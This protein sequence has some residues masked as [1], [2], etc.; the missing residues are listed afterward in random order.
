MN[1]KQK[2]LARKLGA[3]SLAAGAAAFGASA[4][5][6]DAVVVGYRGPADPPAGMADWGL[7]FDYAWYANSVHLPPDPI[8]TKWPMI[9]F[10]LDGTVMA[11]EDL[12][13]PPDP[14]PDWW[15]E[16]A[17]GSVYFT[18]EIVEHAGKASDSFYGN[19][20]PDAG[21][22]AQKLGAGATIDGAQTYVNRDEMYFYD[23]WFYIGGTWGWGGRGYL[24]FYIDDVDG[25]HYG[26]ADICVG[27]GRNEMW[28]G[29]FAYETEPGVGIEAGQGITGD[30]DGDFDVD[31]DDIDLFCANKTGPGV[32]PADPMY[33][34][35]GDGDADDDD[36]DMLIHSFVQTDPAGDAPGTEYGDFDL[37]G[38]VDTTD[39]TILATNFNADPAG[40]AMGNANCDS[41]ID[42]TDLTILATNFGFDKFGGGV[43]EPATLSIL[44][45]GAAGLLKVRRRN[46]A[47]IK[48]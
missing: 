41:I 27:T 22:M 20:S 33:D 28:L 4:V 19:A 5:V 24:G 2:S 31:A 35:D 23:E 9:L 14:H 7:Q 10:K 34:L 17:S 45:V 25:R 36:H 16:T 29:S 43:P 11:V 47:G 8:G 13:S 46:T 18:H 3:Y 21:L 40:W 42:T 32:P 30:F 44:A 37:N 1:D 38:V 15:A 12:N 26:W 39:L 6:S 48:K